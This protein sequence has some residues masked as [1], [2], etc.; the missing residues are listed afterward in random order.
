MRCATVGLKMAL[1]FAFFTAE[2]VAVEIIHAGYAPDKNIRTS[3]T[4]FN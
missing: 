1:D 2:A 3:Y 4:L